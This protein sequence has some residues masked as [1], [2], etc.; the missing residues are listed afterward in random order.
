M[1]GQTKFLNELKSFI[2]NTYNATQWLGQVLGINYSSAFKKMKGG[3]ALSWQDISLICNAVPE[4]AHLLPQSFS[5][6]PAFGGQLLLFDNQKGFI[7]YLDNLIQLFKAPPKHEESGQLRLICKDLP[8][9]F[10][11]TSPELLAFKMAI[12]TNRLFTHGVEL[13][14][15]Q[16]IEKSKRLLD[17]YRAFGSVE[18]WDAQLAATFAAQLQVSVAGGFVPPTQVARLRALATQV[19]SDFALYALDGKKEKGAFQLLQVPFCGLPNSG[20]WQTNTHTVHLT[21]WSEMQLVATTALK[22]IET[23]T[24]EWEGLR[25]FSESLA[26]PRFNRLFFDGLKQQIQAPNVSG[27]EQSFVQR[28]V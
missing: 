23:F 1:E 24:R 19:L 16:I 12:W 8:M 6:Q 27:G 9:F 21:A 20:L 28:V 11:L 15:D 17:L 3:T 22:P 26:A 13:V 14:D 10:Y 5:K 25:R 18:I 7:P 4:A 2:P